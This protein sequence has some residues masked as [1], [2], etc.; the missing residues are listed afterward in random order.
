MPRRP[1][2]A[3]TIGRTWTYVT[4]ADWR[5]ISAALK[6]EF[7]AIRFVHN[8]SFANIDRDEAESALLRLRPDWKKDR[9]PWPAEN[10]DHV[11]VA[12]PQ[13][14]WRVDYCD[15]VEADP[16]NCSTY[17]RGWTSVWLEPLGWKPIWGIRSDSAE[18]DLTNAPALRFIV[19]RCWFRGDNGS[20]YDPIFAGR[21]SEIVHLDD[22]SWNGSFLPG[23][24]ANRKFLSRARRIFDRFTTN[25]LAWVDRK[26]HRVMHRVPK[27]SMERIG[28]HALEWARV[29]P[30]HQ[31]GGENGNRDYLKPID[32]EPPTNRT[33]AE[34]ASKPE[35][36]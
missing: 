21:E 14:A 23:E 31:L 35:L 16:D 2:G 19:R 26:T 32:W 3:R 15:A 27:G 34:A 10:S 11:V 33:S 28:F 6:E 22:A 18:P 7:P 8:P 1:H 13:P 30:G 12:D 17:G 4:P 29:H 25:A 20:S 36:S 24:I 5:D 9:W